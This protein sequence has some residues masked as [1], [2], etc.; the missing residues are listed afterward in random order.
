M[1]TK[2]WQDNNPHYFQVSVQIDT[3]DLYACNNTKKNLGKIKVQC[4]TG[5]SKMWQMKAG[6][7]G[8]NSREKRPLFILRWV[9]RRYL[10]M[11]ERGLPCMDPDIHKYQGGVS[12][13]GLQKEEVSSPI[14][15]SEDSSLVGLQVENKWLRLSPSLHTPPSPWWHK[16]IV[17]RR[18]K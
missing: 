1:P 13:K 16:E 7:Y 6:L 15:N 12:W 8:L 2:V 10:P 18:L 4:F 17:E 9:E 11:P 3:Q 5:T 14:F